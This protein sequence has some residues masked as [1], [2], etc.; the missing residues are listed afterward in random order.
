MSQKNIFLQGLAS[1]DEMCDMYMMYWVQGNTS[2][3]LEVN[4]ELLSV[5][6]IKI[7][8]KLDKI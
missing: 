7:F 4:F 6:K 1:D 3:L 5:K 8:G 2:N